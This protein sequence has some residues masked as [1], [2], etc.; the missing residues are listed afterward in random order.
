M[1]GLNAAVA[2][3]QTDNKADTGTAKPEIDS[4]YM[5]PFKCLVAEK[6]NRIHRGFSLVY[7]GVQRI[8]G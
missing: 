6:G 3:G 2:F 1:C 4:R 8:C 7:T 5:A